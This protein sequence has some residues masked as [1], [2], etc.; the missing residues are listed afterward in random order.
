MVSVT[1]SIIPQ[2]GKRIWTEIKRKIRN[3][4]SYWLSGNLNE[5]V[6]P[7]PMDLLNF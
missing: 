4:I 2:N 3:I 7:S 1:T 5:L 6:N